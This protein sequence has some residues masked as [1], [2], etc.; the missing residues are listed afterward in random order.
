MT[1]EILSGNQ[2]ILGGDFI[3]SPED[4][5]AETEAR[6]KIKTF[7]DKIRY[8]G[9]FS[10][11]NSFVVSGRVFTDA[12]NVPHKVFLHHN[13][14]LQDDDNDDGNYQGEE[15]I[16]L[17]P[18]TKESGLTEKILKIARDIK[19]DGAGLITEESPLRLSFGYTQSHLKLSEGP[20]SVDEFCSIMDGLDFEDEVEISPVVARDFLG[21]IDLNNARKV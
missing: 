19:A 21:E 8:L 12:G 18:E 3:S 7:V 15:V 10:D 2:Y 20:L 17:W 13:D 16:Y 4:F 5:A 6:R 11:S 9:P 14:A 1:T